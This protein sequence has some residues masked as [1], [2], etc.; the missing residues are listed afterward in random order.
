[1]RSSEGRRRNLKLSK[2]ASAALARTAAVGP[3]VR[4]ALAGRVRGLSFASKT[5][6]AHQ[7]FMVMPSKLVDGWLV[8]CH[9]DVICHNKMHLAGLFL[10]PIVPKISYWNEITQD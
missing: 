1:M 9:T 10:P 4:Y 2:M 5:P 8:I 3:G 6:E 7:S